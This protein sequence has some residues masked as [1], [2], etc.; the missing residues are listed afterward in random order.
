MKQGIGGS[1]QDPFSNAEIKA[2]ATKTAIRWSPFFLACLSLG[3]I[4]ALAPPLHTTTSRNNLGGSSYSPYSGSSS[5]HFTGGGSSRSGRGYAKGGSSSSAYGNTANTTSGSG[6]PQQA[7]GYTGSAAPSSLAPIGTYGTTVTGIACK[8][9]VKQFTWSVY[10]PPCVPNFHGNNGGNTSR[11]V[12][13]STI[14]LSYA[15]PPAAEQS[16]ISS[17][18]GSATANPT[19]FAN[20]LETYINFFN[21]Q[22]ELYG[23]HVVLKTFQAQGDYAMEDS[24]Q[25]L[26]AAQADAQTTASMPAFADETFP[27]Y[28]SQYYEQDLAQNHVIGTAGLAMP[29]QWFEQYYP[30][31]IAGGSPTGTAIAQGFSNLICERMAGL[32]AVFSPQYSHTTRKFGLIIPDTPEYKDIEGTLLQSLSRCGIHFAVIEQYD[33]GNTQSYETMAAEYVARMKASGVTTVDCACDPVFPIFLSDAASSQSYFPEWLTIGWGD[34]VTRDYNS[35]EWSHAIAVPLL[36]DGYVLPQSSSTAYKVFLMASGGK[37]PQE[38]YYYA[39]YLYLMS[40]YDG[41]QLAGPD[42]TP[43]TFMRGFMSMP[44]TPI[45]QY[46]SWGG[47]SVAFSLQNIDN[48]IAWWNPNATSNL[49]GSKGAWENCDGGKWFSYNTTAGWGTP[50]TQ[51]KC[52]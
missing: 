8:P 44:Q 38:E 30:Y 6:T 43:Q 17:V 31:E 48:Q 5:T 25:D 51:L 15:I 12:T 35:S 14:T 45:G 3:L 21:R 24:G 23:R 50:H 27:V 46:G 4:V 26:G 18:A 13:G 42:L 39:A 37:P 22:F 32:P 36:G 7:S 10:A 19:A 16:I 1:T 41:L 47:G 28:A 11:G 2:Y 20:D 49:D 34:P 52:F 33:L 40:L 29:D 9:G